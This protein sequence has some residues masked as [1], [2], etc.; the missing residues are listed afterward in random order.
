MK[1]WIA[2]ILFG[3][4]LQG[5]DAETRIVNYLKANVRPGQPVQISR[6]MSDVFKSPEEQRI[7]QRLFNTFLQI[8][9]TIVEFQART[10]RIPKLQELSEQ[11]HFK[12]PGQMD[13]MLRIMES[14]PRIPKFLTRNPATGEI[15]KIDT[16]AIRKDPTFGKAVE[17]TIA[18]WEGTPAPKFTMLSMGKQPLNSAQYQGKP[19]LI[20]FWFTNCPPCV[21]TTPMLVKLHAKYNSKG[22]QMVAANADEVLGLPYKDTDRANYIRKQGITFPVGHMTTDMQKLFG[23]V[24]LF[25]TMFFVNRQGQIVKY[26]VNLQTEA[27]IEAAI[28]ETLK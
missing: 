25:P 8:P 19:H 16:A 20:Y 11:F 3:A 7:L 13:V 4:L 24:S 6:L 10:G 17:R 28:Q 2:A 5:P 22:F 12:V 1:T 9:T 21:Q 23:G 14:D 27:A 26:M 15:T 18:G